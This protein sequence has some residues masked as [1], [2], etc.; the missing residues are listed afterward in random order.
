MQAAFKAKTKLLQDRQRDVDAKIQQEKFAEQQRAAA[1]AQAAQ[2]FERYVKLQHLFPV[3]LG[4]KTPTQN[5]SVR[6]LLPRCDLTL[7]IYSRI[8]PSF[9]C[10]I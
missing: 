8:F 4:F 9:G 10:H 3:E 6:S 7:H 2:E 5:T 1:E